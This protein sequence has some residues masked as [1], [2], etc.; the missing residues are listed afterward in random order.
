MNYAR[1]EARFTLSCVKYRFILY[2]L[3]FILHVFSKSVRRLL[4][5]VVLLVRVWIIYAY[6]INSNTSEIEFVQTYVDNSGKLNFS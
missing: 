5:R 6:Y 2:T 4:S 3:F 1:Y